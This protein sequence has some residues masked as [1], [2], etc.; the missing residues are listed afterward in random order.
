MN[1]SFSDQIKIKTLKKKD[2]LQNLEGVPIF[3]RIR[4][5]SAISYATFEVP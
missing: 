3:Q 4:N 5:P 1:N 2:N